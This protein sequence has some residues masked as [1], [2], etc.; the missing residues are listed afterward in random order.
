MVHA[1][2]RIILMNAVYDSKST[3]KHPLVSSKIEDPGYCAGL[4]MLEQF[5]RLG[6]LPVR[7]EGADAPRK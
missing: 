2:Y 6:R 1:K 3:L 4:A 5:E 7:R